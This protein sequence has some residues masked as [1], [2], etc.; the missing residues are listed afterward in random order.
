MK[1]GF[2]LIELILYM[3][4]ISIFLTVLTSVFLS[5]LDVQLES[6]SLS[7]VEQDGR[8]IQS[9]M[10]Y[11]IHRAADIVTPTSVGLTTPS[12]TLIIGGQNYSYTVSSDALQYVSPV[13]TDN[14][15]SYGSRISN[16]SV[17]RVGNATGNNSL[18]IAF[19]LTSVTTTTT[20]KSEVKDFLIT[21]TLR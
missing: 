9:R 10:V 3:G 6:D 8:Y 1:R 2:T 11:D 5:I 4:L 20:Q 15:T 18:K 12:M 13:G 21:T 19:T 16:F 17:T 14:L 7:S